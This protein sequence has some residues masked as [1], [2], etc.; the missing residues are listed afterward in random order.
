MPDVP[1]PTVTVVICAYTTERWDWLLKLLES[2][3]VQ[4]H[5]PKKVIVV[6]DHNEAL[7]GR[8][9]GIVDDVTVLRNTHPRGL[10]GARNTALEAVD[11]D[12]VA[13]IDDDA[14]AAPD[15]LERLTALYD[16]PDVLAVGGRVDPIWEVGRPG[17]FGQ[18]LDWIVGCSHRG[19][20]RVACEVRN[21]I[22]AN[23]SFRLGVI[24]QMGGFNLSLGRQGSVPS[25]CEETEICIR[26]TM[27]APGSRIVYEPA[28]VVRH[29]VPANRGT[30]RYLLARSWA[31]GVSKARV[32]HVVGY[33][34]ALGPERRYVRSVLLRAFLAGLYDWGRHWKS[35]GLRRAGA[36]LTVLVTTTAGYFRGR[37]LVHVSR[38]RPRHPAQHWRAVQ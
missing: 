25:G 28:A 29:H 19:M 3:R 5:P 14:E 30:F 9:A 31:E 10:S 11:S 35:A 18:E 6:I 38:R 17:F 4:T 23:M 13:F 26:S 2:I 33:K 27:G 34:R 15:W 32:S 12:I 7:Y 22:G 1:L 37:R 36:V 21:V 20:P 16:D 8:L 24:R